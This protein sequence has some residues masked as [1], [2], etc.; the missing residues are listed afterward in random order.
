MGHLDPYIYVIG[1]FFENFNK[2]KKNPLYGVEEV[3]NI[4]QCSFSCFFL[5]CSKEKIS[6]TNT[7]PAI[8]KQYLPVKAE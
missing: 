8:K 1:K 3:S 5:L 4:I 7:L 6:V 2:Y